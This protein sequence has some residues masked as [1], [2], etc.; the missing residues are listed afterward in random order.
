MF[1]FHACDVESKANGDDDTAGLKNFSGSCQTGGN[2]EEAITEEDRCQL[3]KIKKS[4]FF[5]LFFCE[6]VNQATENES[7]L[8]L[9]VIKT[10]F[11]LK[12]QF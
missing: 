3:R 9:V 6:A 5:S 12:L 11:N 8:R 7:V 1:F 4:S 2:D 10:L